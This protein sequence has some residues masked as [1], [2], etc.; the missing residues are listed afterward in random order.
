MNTFIWVL[1]GAALGW[2]AFAYLNLSEGRG[3]LASIVIG[4][5]GGVLGGKMIAPMLTAPV[6][7]AVAADFRMSSLVIAALVAS[8]LLVIANLIYKRWD[9]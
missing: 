5:M 1:A 7:A 8:T 2:A 9:I 3:K 4:A 6:P